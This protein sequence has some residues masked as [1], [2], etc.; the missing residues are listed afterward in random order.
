MVTAV[1]DIRKQEAVKF[2]FAV[3]QRRSLASLPK[4]Q[5]WL[6]RAVYFLV[7]WQTADG[8][9]QEAICTDEVIAKA[10]VAAGGANWFYHKLPV[11]ATLPAATCRLEGVRFPLSE[12]SKAYESNG[13]REVP[14]ICP[15]TG[16]LCR[17]HDSLSYSELAKAHDKIKDLAAL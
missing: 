17:P 4:W 9:E 8:E 2:Q 14:I 11:N 16:T 6:V 12:A 13:K 5:R 7:D 3:G 1:T 15:H 10:I